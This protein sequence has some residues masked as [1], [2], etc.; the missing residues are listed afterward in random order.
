MLAAAPEEHEEEE[1]CLFFVALSRARDVLVLSRAQRYGK[2]NKK[3]SPL[4]ENLEKVL[5]RAPDDPPT[6]TASEPNPDQHPDP[7]RAPLPYDVRQLEVYMR[8][9]RQFYYEFVLG[10]SGKREDTAY[11]QFHVCVYRVLRWMQEQRIANRTVDVPAALAKLNDTWQQQ[12]PIDH[13]YAEVYRERAENMVAR[14][15]GRPTRSRARPADT[16]QWQVD[17]PH[18]RVTFTPD[19]VEQQEDGSVLVERLRTGR[20]TR[21]ELDK[22]IYALYQSAAPPNAN[23]Q[24]RYLSNDHTEPVEL[25]PRS[26]QTRLTHYDK[27]ISGILRE[28]FPAA[29][30]D[31]DCPRCPHYFICPL[32]QN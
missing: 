6:W 10:L 22:D 9:P 4:L 5:P 32:G 24:I 26:V 8:C 20:P 19:Y 21:S 30:N 27:A 2:Q 29:P 11:V 17:L 7:A 14:W 16:D 12:G 3:P 31:R 23:I 18:G 13:P 25:K 28:D 1:E 15:A